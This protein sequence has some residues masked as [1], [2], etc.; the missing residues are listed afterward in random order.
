MALRLEVALHLTG[1]C[2]AEGRKSLGL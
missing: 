1:L 2:L